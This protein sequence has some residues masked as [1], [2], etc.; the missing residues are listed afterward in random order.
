MSNGTPVN[1]PAYLWGRKI[2]QALSAGPWLCNPNN[3]VGEHPL[4]AEIH[5]IEDRPVKEY[6]ERQIRTLLG[7]GFIEGRWADRGW[8]TYTKA[9]ECPALKVDS[10]TWVERENERLRR[11]HERTQVMLDREHEIA[12]E[13]RKFLDAP[14]IAER[15]RG[16]HEV[17][18]E[19]KVLDRLAA[20]E[21]VVGRIEAAV[22]SLTNTNG[23]RA[24]EAVH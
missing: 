22:A 19:N 18:S 13:H 16:A 24:E 14:L 20:L 7:Y 6:S 4:L 9:R 17:L 10:M 3:L 5:A 15:Q 2:W 23:H 12:Q 21:A 11:E 8:I 1:D